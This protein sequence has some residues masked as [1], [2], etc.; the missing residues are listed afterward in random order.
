MLGNVQKLAE[1]LW[2]IQGEMPP[3]SSKAPDPCNIAVYKAED[4]LYLIDTSCTLEMRASLKKTIEAARP[5]ETITLINTNSHL[6]HICN[7]DLITQAGAKNVHHYI[8]QVGM[9]DD[10][11]DAPE[12]FSRQFDRMDEYFDPFSSYQVYRLKYASAG[13]MR[14]LIGLW[15]GRRKV[16][17]MLFRTLFKKFEPVRTS[18]E[19]MTPLENLPSEDISLFGAAWKGWVLG[20]KDVMV[21]EGRAH[22]GDE[23]FVY[24]PKHKT[25]CT[26]DLTFPLFPT[27]E[28]SSRE[29]ILHCLNQF[30]TMTQNGGVEIL[31]DGHSH[32]VYLGK[33]S[34]IRFI[35]QLINDHIKFETILQEIFAKK[36]GLKPVEV[37]SEFKQY[38]DPVVKKYLEAEFPHSPPSLQNVMVT[39]LLQMGFQARG[40]YRHKRFYRTV[41]AAR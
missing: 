31:I 33:E 6:D 14:D 18:R 16:L 11:L 15:V 39:T 24:I 22:T 30:L 10:M 1:T 13:F 8:S 35:S 38:P 3:D 19:T 27:W 34:V 28:D 7:N 12:Y 2:Y 26:G 40:K 41:A 25:L 20:Q 37:Y 32:Q 29:R 9:K 17:K 5:F 23:V 21:L 4:R 36:D